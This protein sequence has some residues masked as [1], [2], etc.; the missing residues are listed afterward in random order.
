MQ[1]IIYLRGIVATFV[2]DVEGRTVAF[3]MT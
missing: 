2:R 1:V 3:E